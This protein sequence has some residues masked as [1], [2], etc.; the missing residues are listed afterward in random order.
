MFKKLYKVILITGL[1]CTAAFGQKVTTNSLIREMVDLHRLTDVSSADYKTVQYSSYDRRSDKPNGPGWKQ[2]SDGFGGEPIPGFEAVI[3]EP[4]EGGIGKYLVC[5]I[6]GPGALVRLWA[7]DHAVKGDVEVYLDGE[8]LYEGPGIKFFREF[9]DYF[10]EELGLE[11]SLFDGAYRQRDAVYFPIPFEKSLKVIYIGD[12]KEQHFYHLQARL[13]NK[14]TKL[15]TFELSDIRENL[16]LIEEV[17]GI[18]RN[19]SE[20]YKYSGDRKHELSSDVKPGENKLIWQSEDAG[21]IEKLTLEINADD[22]VAALRHTLLYIIFDDYS[23]PQVQSPLGDFF[24]SGPG[25]VPYDSLPFTVESDGT[26]TCRLPMPF[27]KN[28]KV[29]AHN[30]GDQEVFL[31]G[32]LL[33]SGKKP[34]E[35]DILHF[36]AR[37]RIDHDLISMDPGIEDL[38]FLCARGEGRYVGTSIIVKNPNPI[39]AF[40]GCW[41]GE[42]DE[43]IFVDDDKLPS[44]FGTGSEDYF[45]YSWCSNRLFN[46]A[47]AVQPRVDGPG[48]RGFTNNIRYHILDDIPFEHNLFFYMELWQHERTEGISYAR[49]P[50]YYGRNIVDDHVYITSEDVRKPEMTG[51]WDPVSKKQTK[52][53]E[54]FQ[55]EDLVETGQNYSVKRNGMWAKDKLLVWKPEQKGEKFEFKLDVTESAEYRLHFTM[56]MSPDS[57]WYTAE[58]NGIDLALHGH[59]L[60]RLKT[61]NMTMAR[62]VFSQRLK[63]QPGEYSLVFTNESREKGDVIG[64]DFFWLEKMRKIPLKGEGIV[65]VKEGEEM[66][67]VEVSDSSIVYSE[68][69]QGNFKGSWSNAA[70][71]WVRFVKRG[72]YVDLLFDVNEAGTYDLVSNFTVAPDYGIVEISINDQ[73]LKDGVDLYN[74]HV[75]QKKIELGTAEL[76]KG[77]NILRLKVIGKNE[78]STGY[79]SGLDFIKI[80]PTVEN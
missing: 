41:W 31:T 68:Q 25:L 34:E 61:E 14:D 56:Q 75:N 50:Y 7:A 28:V 40:G 19:P 73:L 5:D 59:R 38:P 29:Y 62:T 44:I 60:R 2:N 57:G 46:Y 47:Y 49:L 33:T 26:M 43:K 66:N 32:E 80:E 8:L 35:E 39:P 53:A 52:R 76:K 74:D 72:Q 17:G 37:W 77:T 79:Y 24:G 22:M 10:A 6:K 69:G 67:V 42:G 16:Q 21:S 12:I 1:L 78:K 70:H 65:P 51:N 20:N 3:D 36:Y 27:E 55:A 15:E 48:N 13:Y 63:L 23:M 45:N 11:K 64:F 4:D 30:L 9:T 54:F 18:L 71:L 58:L